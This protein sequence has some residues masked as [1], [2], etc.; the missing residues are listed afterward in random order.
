MGILILYWISLIIGV[1][2]CVYTLMLIIENV[3]LCIKSEQ[4]ELSFFPIIIGTISI[5]FIILSQHIYNL[6]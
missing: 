4:Y 2:G 3:L 5:M 6:I 1:F